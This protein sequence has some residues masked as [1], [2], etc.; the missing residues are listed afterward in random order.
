MKEG[1]R[2]VNPY[3]LHTSISILQFR[4]TNSTEP[5]SVPK[6]TVTGW[7]GPRRTPGGCRLALLGPLSI[8]DTDV[9]TVPPDESA[10]GLITEDSGPP[11]VT[12][13]YCLRSQAFADLESIGQSSAEAVRSQRN[14][15]H[16][17]ERSLLAFSKWEATLAR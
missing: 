1:G 17:I 13:A 15:Y 8:R 14:G 12:D 7:F 6:C 2:M 9:R 16:R 3:L 5:N 11:S 4:S 10:F